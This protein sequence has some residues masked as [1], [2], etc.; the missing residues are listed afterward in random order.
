[1]ETTNILVRNAWA[2]EREIGRLNKRAGKVGIAP[3]A[4]CN[5]GRKTVTQTR[6]TVISL[7]GE[8]REELNRVPVEVSE[9]A[10]T[11]PDMSEYKWTLCATIT[12]L[13]DG[14]IFVDPY[15]KGFDIKAWANADPCLCQHCKTVRR[16]NLSYVVRHNEDGR[17][18]QVGRNCFADYVGHA[19]LLKL[20]FMSL[21]VSVLR[22]GDDD[23]WDG[24]P[25]G[26]TR[27]MQVV[28]CRVVIAI[29]EA[30]AEH[31]GW[32]YNQKDDEGNIVAEGTHRQAA[33]FTGLGIEMPDWLKAKLL[34]PAH[35]AKAD[36]IIARLQSFDAPADDDFALSLAYCSNFEV[37]PDKKAGMV[38]Y[39]GQFLRNYD[40]KLEAEARKATRQHIGTVGT[41]LTL[42]LKCTRV[43][44]FDSQFGTVYFNNF[45][46]AQG[47]MVLWKTGT[48]TGE[49]GKE[50][51]VKATIKAHSEWRDGK[52]TEISRAKIQ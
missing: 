26:G 4:Y 8:S 14:S 29:A 2:F 24:G 30:L 35:M 6:V 21:V 25:E 50:Y 39:A 18:L 36:A 23:I 41:R 44:S 33:R 46:D 13:E 34:D 52:Q 37:V 16:R 49:E 5:L 12:R 1:M 20:E 11:L 19:G 42:V 7:D 28:P 51:T 31:N 27:R 32:H 45:E 22:C 3:I 38:A 40:R 15:V 10:V 9:Y 47:N 43:T 48:F 17:V